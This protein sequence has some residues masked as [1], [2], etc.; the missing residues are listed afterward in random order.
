[1]ESLRTLDFVEASETCIRRLAKSG[2]SVEM[3]T[4]FAQIQSDAIQLQK[5]YFTKQLS[6]EYNDFTEE[7]AFWFRIFHASEAGGKELVGLVGARRDNLNPGEFV[8]VLG[9]Q[10]VRLYGVNG[11]T[12]II[13]DVF[14]PVFHDI[15]GS[16]VY[17]GD[18]FIDESHRGRTKLDKRALL[19][20]LFITAHQKWSF[21]W[22]YAF[23][24]KEHGERG[25]LVTY[26]FTRVY[27][28]ALLWKDP[29]SER[30]DTDQLACIDRADLA[31]L[32]RRLLDVPDI[33]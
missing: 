14:P 7:S 16:V 31:Y 8:D 33:L 28:A 21:D 11:E 25:Y 1:M 13:T 20:L 32:V 26:G 19:V 9:R 22:L 12:P 30:S 17:I 18:L 24:R 29:P 5:P 4:D 2:I 3:S 6:S 23:V 10:M 27:L 15:K